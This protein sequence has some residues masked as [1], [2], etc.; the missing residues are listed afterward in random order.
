MVARNDD[1]NG[2]DLIDRCVGGVQPTG[3]GIEEDLSLEFTSQ[4]AGK[5]SVCRVIGHDRTLPIL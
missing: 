3:E 5:R 2:L 1:A 4:A